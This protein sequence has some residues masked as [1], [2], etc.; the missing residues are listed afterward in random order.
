MKLRIVALLALFGGLLSVGS[1]A[2]QRHGP[3]QAIY[4]DLGKTHDGVNIYCP[5]PVLNGGW[6]APFAFDRCGTSVD[7]KIGFPEDDFRLAPFIANTA[8]NK[9]GREPISMFSG[10]SS[11]H[12]AKI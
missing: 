8:F 6:P 3:D 7:G 2:I 4:C 5:K 12:P 11:V 9:L 1:C 10:W